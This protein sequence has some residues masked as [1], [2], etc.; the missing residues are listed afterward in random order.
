MRKLCI[1]AA[2][3]ASLAVTDSAAAQ[4]VSVPLSFNHAV[5]TAGSFKDVALISPSTQPITATAEFDTSTGAFTISPADLSFPAYSFTTPVPG[6]LQVS[7]NGPASGQ[8]NP[9]TGALT[10]T[11]DYI[12]SINLTGIGTCMADTGSQ[13]YST[14]NSNVY[15]GVAFPATAT[16]P[17]TGPGAFT[18]GWSTIQTSGSACTLVSG[19][20]AGPG[21]LWISKN[22]SPPALSI[23]A[24]SK[25]SGTVGK[26]ATI[27]VTVSDTGNVAA[28]DVSVCTAAPSS[29]H[30]TGKKCTKI[31]SLTGGA[32]KTIKVKLK[33]AKAGKFTVKFTASASGLTNVQRKVALKLKKK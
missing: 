33:G 9:A 22:V 7:L 11:A 2:A 27:S 20:I 17:A 25:A 1:L 6:T 21:G 29:V 10:M 31:A 12:A 32:K 13:T 19:D 4:T 28:T 5:L 3:L 18:G 16:G 26:T 14:S 8:F 15:P 23:S 24:R 30:V